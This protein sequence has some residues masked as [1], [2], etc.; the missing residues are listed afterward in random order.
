M[1]R[2]VE[3][4]LMN[5]YKTKLGS[6][7]IG[8]LIWQY[9]L[10]SIAGS[11]LL[12]VYNIIDRIMVGGTLGP[13][14]LS[15]LALAFPFTILQMAFG[16]LIGTGA[17]SRISIAMGEGDFQNAEKTL[18]H[19]FTLTFITSS[20]AI[21]LSYLFMHKLL[22]LVGSSAQTI[23]FA[24]DFL[25][26]ITPGILFSSL[27]YGFNNIMRASGYP[28]KAMY[29]MIICAVLNA[30]LSYLFIVRLQWGIQGA[31]WASNITNIVG[32]G[33]VI[34]HFLSKHEPFRLKTKNLIL[35]LKITG[36]IFSI[37]V[38]PFS[39]QVASSLVAIF[40]NFTLIKQGGDQAIGAY[41]IIN[42]LNTLVVMFIIGLNQGAQPI[43]GYN[44][45]A[46]SFKRMFDTL[47]YT[48]LAGGA[49]ASIGFMAGLLFSHHI[50]VWFTSDPQLRQVSA[51]ALQIS[52]LL[53]PL[54]GIQI[55]IT[56][57][58][59]SIGKT[60]VSIFLS[61]TRQFLFLIP[62]TLILMHFLGVK[63]AW[64]AMPVSD[65]LAFTTTLSALFVFKKK[66]QKNDTRTIT[67]NTL[68]IGVGK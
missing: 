61:L 2:K 21:L 62:S 41:G 45:G 67:W 29:T 64:V 13:Q 38:S 33:W 66:Y 51:D 34:K 3:F 11:I 14:A 23:C 54:M 58:F 16:M 65:A 68:N 26:I 37:G 53:F 10:P 31:A 4:V 43:I 60:K 32:S 25:T 59:Q 7:R 19:A 42:S 18:G 57:F 1:I 6:G 28:V 24:E 30:T 22:Q 47:R 40:V 48:A 36:D 63:G 56:K 8:S 5:T 27:N 52:V 44:Y 17:A 9:S 55:V 50:T 20:T 12:S 49:F 15:G 35:N 39:M 46:K